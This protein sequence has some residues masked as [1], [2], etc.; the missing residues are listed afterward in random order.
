MPKK[1]LLWKFIL[2]LAVIGGAFA[3]WMTASVA[4]MFL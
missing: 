2:I 3:S 4:G 1:N